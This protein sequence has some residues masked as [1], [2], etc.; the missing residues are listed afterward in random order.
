MH[1]QL[2]NCAVVSKKCSQLLGAAVPWL[3]AS[4]NGDPGRAR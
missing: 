4:C 1:V 3:G 2:V